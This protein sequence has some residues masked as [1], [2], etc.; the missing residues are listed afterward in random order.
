M[1]VC[2]YIYMASFF[3]H[4]SFDGHLGCFYFL[5]V[6]NNAA[7]NMAVQV[8]FRVGV[9]ISFGYSPRSGIA[10]LYGSYTSFFEAPPRCFP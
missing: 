1:C 10:G 8:S 4:L 5:A 3:I 2:V 9:F 7:M 6:V